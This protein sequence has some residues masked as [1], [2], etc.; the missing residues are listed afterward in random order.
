MK[1][2]EIANEI[3]LLNI[4][5][6]EIDLF[7]GQYKLKNGIMYNSYVIFDEKITIM[8]TVDKSKSAEWLTSLEEILGD[9]EPHYFV[10][11]HMEPDHGGSI[12]DL[13]E[14]YPNLKVVGSAKTFQLMEQF[15]DIDLKD[16]RIVV[17]EGDALELGARSLTFCMAPMVHWPEVMVAYENKEGILF[18]ADAFGTFEALEKDEAWELEARRYYFN[19]VGK[20][21]AQ[22]QNLLK[23]ASNLEIKKLCPLH[24]PVLSENLE[25]YMEKYQIW[26]QYEPENEGVFIGYASFYGHTKEAAIIL[27]ELLEQEGG[28]DVVLFDLAREDLSYALSYAFQY[29]KMV[30]VATSYDGGVMPAVEE[31]LHH[32]KAKNYQ[33][34]KVGYIENGSW[35]PS[36]IRT[37]REIM[38]GLKQI[39]ECEMKVSIKSSLKDVDI[40]NI[41]LLSKELLS[42]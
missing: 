23:K 2:T 17:K 20:Y 42:K 13:L 22:V 28:K 11:L 35:A 21:G 1:S 36:A 29:D 5:D 31:F 41:K 26:S 25:F 19:I 3:A 18:S 4:Y 39:E 6:E 16:N 27:K 37:M 24:G 10:C 9:R 32:L 38:S 7:E 12:G 14:K 30:L 33:K 15:F 40:E 8:D 34:R